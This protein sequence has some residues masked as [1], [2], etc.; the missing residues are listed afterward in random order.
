M[1]GEPQRAHVQTTA[2]VRPDTIRGEVLGWG[3]RPKFLPQP[4]RATGPL[5]G[6]KMGEK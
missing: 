5:L 1:E 2:T 3:A 4:S 6:G